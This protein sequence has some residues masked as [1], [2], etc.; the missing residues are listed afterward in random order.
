MASYVHMCAHQHPG[1]EVVLSMDL[2]RHHE[3][4]LAPQLDI[5]DELLADVNPFPEPSV[6]TPPRTPSPGTPD[7]AFGMVVECGSGI[8]TPRGKQPGRCRMNHTI[9]TD[10]LIYKFV[11]VHGPRWRK[12]ACSLGGRKEGYS[13]DVVRNRYVRLMEAL[14][15]P[16]QTHCDRTKTPRKPAKPV[17]VW[18]PA[19]DELIVKGVEM[20]GT[21]WGIIADFF[22]GA[23]TPHAVRNRAN[24]I[25]AVQPLAN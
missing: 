4:G 20:H 24:R 23:R 21:R 9:V 12:L 5:I 6:S 1:G 19:Q 14:G 2:L 7:N 3:E 15:T 13:D 22:E 8:R 18:T 10:M 11:E 17:E 25:G 16:Y